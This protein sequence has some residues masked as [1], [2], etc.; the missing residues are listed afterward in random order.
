MYLTQVIGHIAGL[1]TMILRV[2]EKVIIV[3]YSP[4]RN[5]QDGLRLWASRHLLPEDIVQSHL[6]VRGGCCVGLWSV[7]SHI[8]E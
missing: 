6:C 8:G 4:E 1:G 5:N 3:H 2:T 7:A